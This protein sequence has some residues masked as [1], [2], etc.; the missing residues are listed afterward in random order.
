MLLD[1]HSEEPAIRTFV[2]LELSR[3]TWL[4]TSVSPGGEKMSKHG[5]SAGNIVALLARLSELKQK[6]F[7]RIGKSLQVVA[8]QEA[9]LDGLWIHRV[10]QSE[11]VE[12]HV[13]D[14]ASIATSR[15]RRRATTFRLGVG[16][17]ETGVSSPLLRHTGARDRPRQGVIGRVAP[18]ACTKSKSAAQN[19]CRHPRTNSRAKRSMGGT[20]DVAP[21]GSPPF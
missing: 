12:S 2:S 1:H 17:H 8:I 7:A 13:V 5:E 10:L 4:I 3:S 9:G 6:V 19:V 21:G 20:W 15:R 18:G 14:A 16:D 11:G